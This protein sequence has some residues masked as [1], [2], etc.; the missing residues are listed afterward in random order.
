MYNLPLPNLCATL[1]TDVYQSNAS[2]ANVPALYCVMPYVVTCVDVSGVV[3]WDYS[4]LCLSGEA[5]ILVAKL[6]NN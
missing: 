5:L 4:V 3:L 1:L 2:S 6:L